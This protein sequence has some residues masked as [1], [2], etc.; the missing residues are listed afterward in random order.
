LKIIHSGNQRRIEDN[1]PPARARFD[2]CPCLNP[3]EFQEVHIQTAGN[4][5]WP[6]ERQGAGRF[7]KRGKAGLLLQ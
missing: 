2:N 3:E 5:P 1:A 7:P 6:S 4:I